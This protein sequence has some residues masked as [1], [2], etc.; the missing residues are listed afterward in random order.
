MIF[1][2][3]RDVPLTVRFAATWKL[4]DTILNL[5]PNKFMHALETRSVAKGT[6]LYSPS[7]WAA[8]E[9]LKVF[10]YHDT[11]CHVIF[12]AVDVDLFAPSVEDQT[13]PGLVV[14]ANGIEPRKGI[15][16]LLESFNLWG[17]SHPHARLVII[18]N[19]ILKPVNGR[20]LGERCLELVAQDL[21]SRIQFTGRLD[22]ITG[23]LPWLHRAQACVY[24]SHIETFGIAPVEAMAVGKPVINSRTGPGPELIEDGVSGLLCD[25]TS[26]TDIAAKIAQ[27]FDR[28]EWAR[29]IGRRAR[30]RVLDLFNHKTWGAKCEAFYEQCVADV[31]KRGPRRIGR[32]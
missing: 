25:P 11:P 5:P 13:E 6:H 31:A 1:G 9:S 28:P 4:Y 24:P 20:T 7:R 15:R 3:P 32:P 30:V 29:E 22:R 12:N 19:E 27:V 17:R 18:G 2:G 8:D 16:E 26:P 10:G 23:M 21:R 14:Y